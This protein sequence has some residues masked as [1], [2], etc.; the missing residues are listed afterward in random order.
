VPDEYSVI[1]HARAAV[2]VKSNEQVLINNPALDGGVL[3]TSENVAHPSDPPTLHLVL[4]TRGSGV[5]LEDAAERLGGFAASTASLISLVMNA[6]IDE[7]RLHVVS[8]IVGPGERGRFIQEVSMGPALHDPVVMRPL[9]SAALGALV[10]A[11]DQHPIQD[12]LWQASTHYAEALRSWHE[13]NSIR[14]SQSVFMAAEALERA[15]VKRMLHDRGWGK[16]GREDLAAELEL[17]NG[18]RGLEPHIRR[19]VVFADD[20]SVGSKLRAGSDEF[21]H[22]FK[23]L[24]AV[25][26]TIDGRWQPGARMVRRA[27]LAEVGLA[28]EMFDRLTADPLN[29]P[30][31]AWS[32]LV[33]IEGEFTPAQNADAPEQRRFPGGRLKFTGGVASARAQGKG[34]TEEHQFRVDGDMSSMPDGM[35]ARTHTRTT[36]IP[37]NPG[38]NIE[39]TASTLIQRRDGKVIT[40]LDE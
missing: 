11:M 13:H 35:Q 39:E 27:L 31:P 20:P 32:P 14:V 15:I 22:S 3:I 17:T 28:S 19:T 18:V 24:D 40:Q 37:S 26:T 4:E 23:S 38:G 1:L 16:E 33:S 25:R 2:F 12:M 8:D 6:S 30:L 34:E 29:T 21:E 36:N 5:S 9:N 10:D 7:A